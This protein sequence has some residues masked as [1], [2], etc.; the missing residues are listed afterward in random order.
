MKRTVICAL[1]FFFAVSVQLFGQGYTV[2][3]RNIR[4][5]PFPDNAPVRAAAYEEFVSAVSDLQ[6][7]R[8]E[9]IS[10]PA[11]GRRVKYSIQTQNEALYLLFTNEHEGSFP[12]AS[13]GSYII[14]R[15]LGDGRFRQI[16]IFYKNDPG[17]FIRVFPNADRTLMDVYLS[18][19]LLYSGVNLP[20]PFDV[21]L[22]SSF[23]DIIAG[24]PSLVDWDLLL[25]EYRPGAF[26]DLLGMIDTIRER[27]PD[28]PDAEDGAMDDRGR[29][30]SIE[31]GEPLEQGGV[32]CS[33]FA[34][35]VVDGLYEPVA[36]EY[37]DIADLTRRHTD[38]RGNRWSDRREY[39]RDPFFGLDWTRNLACSL[40]AVESED[41]LSYEACDVT[42]GKLG[43]YRED[44]GFPS[45]D[46]AFVFYE[47]AV[48][49]P[50]SLYLGSVNGIFGEDPPLRQ[51]YHVAV[52]FPVL[53]QE[54]TL[55]VTVF[56]RG[57]ETS[58]SAFLARYPGEFVH[59][60][61]IRASGS[62]DPPI[63]SRISMPH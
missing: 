33:G 19:G 9:I 52:F 31:T 12:L 29:W 57:K 51:H 45:E 61:E 46:L 13:A 8:D 24:S 28:L 30:V 41:L 55:D 59:L 7:H 47:H 17:S 38:D 32:N 11:D 18:G 14:K 36:G 23:D 58:F 56:E 2:S 15:S 21:Y 43:E 4:D 27:L 26:R 53:T 25:P 62:F 48:R 6:H 3:R 37:L 44:I 50:G 39:E 1:F 5:I 49:N 16:K 63:V 20:M 34:K 35:W 22:T 60:V 40:L 42:T 10:L 54:G